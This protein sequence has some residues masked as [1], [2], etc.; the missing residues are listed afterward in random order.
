MVCVPR[1]RTLYPTTKSRRHKKR[2]IVKKSS[3]FFLIIFVCAIITVVV[4]FLIIFLFRNPQSVWTQLLLRIGLP[5]VVYILVAAFLQGRSAA[6]FEPDCFAVQGEEYARALKKLGSAPIKMLALSVLLE[7]SLLGSIFIQGEKAGIQAEI[8]TPLFLAALSLGVLI[9]AFVYV[10]SDSLVSKTLISCGLNAYPRDLREYRQ[11]LKM[12]IIPVVMTLLSVLFACS[13]ILLAMYGAGISLS[14]VNARTWRTAFILIGLFF[15]SLALLASTVKKNA[16]TLFDSIIDQLENLSSTKKDRTKRISICSVDELG[17]IAG[18]INS[19]CDNMGNWLREIKEDQ[20]KLSSSGVELEQNAA[21][22]AV[23][24]AR[25]SGGVEQVRAKAQNQLRSVSE[26]SVAVHEIAKNIE[27]LD[28][29]ISRQSSS[30]SGASAVV[31]EMVGNIKSIGV[32]MEKMLEQFKTVND[33]ASDCAVIQKESG[34]KVQEIVKESKA[35]QEANK[36]I[37]TI[38]AQT[39]LLS[40]NAAIEAAHAGDAG[41]GFSVVADEIR[42]LAENSSRE[43]Q[44]ISAE[45]KQIAGTITSVV[46]GSKSSEQAFGQMS[47]RISETEKLVSEVNNAIQEQQEGADQM[48]GAL[49]SMNDI[50]AEVKTGSKEMSAGNAAMLREMDKLQSDSREISGGVDEMAQ[51]VASVNKNAKQVSALA[52]NAQ[53]SIENITVI[54]DSFGL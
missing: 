22:M 27:S 5:G 32:M 29:A 18:M 36:I 33:A 10:L 52:A 16:A 3:V 20:N 19:F 28:S 45:L 40:M 8:K 44:K 38:A 54:V 9:S 12:L 25:I 41:R 34:G 23:S 53:S 26:S 42:K 21:D 6:S 30:M 48:L 31:E 43:S 1:R 51:S 50:T 4:N 39:N 14:M 47:I 37:A 2:F 7:L 35:L 13:M 15:L 17:T 24:I 11:G 49:K 46:T